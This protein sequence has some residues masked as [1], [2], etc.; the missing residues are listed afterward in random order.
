[1]RS[2]GAFTLIEMLIVIAI[3]T[4][5]LGVML[6]SLAGA[7]SAARGAACTSNQRQMLIAWTLYANANRDRAMPLGDER[8]NQRLVYWW[9]SLE[10]TS[11]DSTTPKID[12]SRGFL[13]PYLDTALHAKSPLECAA[14]AWGTY[15][16]QPMSLSPAQPTSTYGYNGY[17]LAPASTPGWNRDIA[18]Q[19]WK[20]LSD[21]AHPN[22]LFVFADTMLPG[23]TPRNC[24]LLDPPMLFSRT[25]G[26]SANPSPTT[27]FRHGSAAS[28]S[29]NAARADGSVAN[30]VAKP[31][32]I[33]D[34]TWRIGSVSI[35]ND[36]AYVPDWSSWR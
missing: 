24:A 17:F 12:A 11:T 9:G 16:A 15:R 13:M 34:R 14:Q 10:L 6:P 28:P 4:I 7:R 21:L 3:V 20:R 19:R 29:T 30:I 32:W 36:P 31:D 2:R 27:S 1:M 25:S 18:A 26:W 35:S 5:L 33:V 8:S 23:S 22:S